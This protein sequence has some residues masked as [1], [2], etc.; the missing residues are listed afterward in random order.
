MIFFMDKLIF[1]F[2][3]LFLLPFLTKCKLSIIAIVPSVAT[4]FLLLKT[5]IGQDV[6]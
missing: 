1:E 3:F 6:A 2:H 5:C 4:A